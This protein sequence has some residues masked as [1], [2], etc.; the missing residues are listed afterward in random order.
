M[1]N[2]NPQTRLNI[3]LKAPTQHLVNAIEKSKEAISEYI[4]VG[5]KKAV[6][7]FDFVT[8]I[9]EEVKEMIKWE[10]KTAI[11]MSRLSNIIKNKVKIE[12]E[13][14]VMAKVK[15]IEIEVKKKKRIK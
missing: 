6:D 2:Y 9:K 14:A 4:E 10:L 3:E 8:A 13:A 15:G 12:V 1:E 11:A 7:E 5:C